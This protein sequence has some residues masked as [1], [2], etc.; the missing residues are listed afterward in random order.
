[1]KRLIY[2]LRTLIT[3]PYIIINSIF[4]IVLLGILIYSLFPAGGNHYPIPSSMEILKE[5][6]DISSGL[7]RCFSELMGGRLDSAIEFNE[8]G[9]RIFL[10]FLLQLLMRPVFSILYIRNHQ[11][12]IWIYLDAG[13][14]IILFIFAFLPF[15]QRYIRMVNALI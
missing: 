10:F 12:V 2:R 3:I 9:P 15:I 8:H 5:G 11:A 13:I 1:M 7:S 4:I 14:S 6:K